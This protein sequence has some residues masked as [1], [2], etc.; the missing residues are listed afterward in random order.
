MAEPLSGPLAVQCKVC[1]GSAPCPLVPS[2]DRDADRPPPE[3]PSHAHSGPSSNNPES[4]PFQGQEERRAAGRIGRGHSARPHTGQADP[5]L[6]MA[7]YSGGT[8][9]PSHRHPN[10]GVGGSTVAIGR[11]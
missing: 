3:R 7:E 10:S 5:A 9:D 4:T 11:S 6:A 1:G 2:P 8:C